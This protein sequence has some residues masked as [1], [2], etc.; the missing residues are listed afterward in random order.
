MKRKEGPQSHLAQRSRNQKNEFPGRPG[1]EGPS[2]A[3]AMEHVQRMGTVRALKATDQERRR[4][5]RENSPGWLRSTTDEE[6]VSR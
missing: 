1:N 5:K 3:K 2:Y 4:M 6:A